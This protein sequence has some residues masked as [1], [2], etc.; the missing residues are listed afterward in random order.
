MKLAI[1]PI[2]FLF[3]IS[4][5]SIKINN[6][7]LDQS[8]S[9]KKLH[10]DI[11]YTEKKLLKLHPNLDWYISKDSLQ[12]EFNQIKKGINT[13]LKPNELFT[14]LAPTIANIRQGHLTLYPLYKKYTKKDV[15]TFGKQKG[16]FSRF[17]YWV[18][19][20]N[21]LYIKE[22]KDRFLNIE[23]GTEILE[24]NGEKIADL[25]NL[26]SAYVT[27]DG[28]NTTHKKYALA[29][30]WT[31][32]YYPEKGI[33][34]SIKFK[35]KYKDEIKEFWAHR[36]SIDQKKQKEETK[37]IHDSVN[38]KDNKNLH[39]NERLGEYNRELK[40]LDSDST[41]AYMKIRSF[42]GVH[43]SAF[44]KKSFNTI[45]QKKV[46]TLIIDVRDNLGGSLS[47][48]NNLYS[49]LTINKKNFTKKIKITN[50]SSIHKTNYF[51]RNT[52]FGKIMDVVLF[53]FAYLNNTLSVKKDN[54]GEYYFHYKFLNEIKE[55]KKD[56]Y[57]GD[58]Y[59]LI[60]GNSF[61]A[62]SIITAKL[63]DDG[64][65]ILVGEETGG[66]HNGTV[67]GRYSTQKLPHSKL[68][69]PIGIMLIQPDVKFDEN[70]KGVQPDV[71]I[72]PSKEDIFSK[73][74]IVLQYV[75][76]RVKIE[77]LLK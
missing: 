19:D 17:S 41:I 5:N 59:F 20:D 74:D 36:E 44:Y 28:Y 70:N 4:C 48:I 45:Q 49:Y 33:F 58:L 6:Q 37:K 26:Y 51:E 11:H 46:K 65:A 21:R 23:P 38:K 75:V 31:A 29:R 10:K 25:M 40:F 2:L 14:R 73:N 77:N 9:I 27:G 35:T 57:Q 76:E 30:R 56:A 66:A 60:N 16:I 42:S 3:L 32:L 12:N 7:N 18:D 43:S 34:D 50:P 53:P 69:I 71:E 13:P 55:I 63:K 72:I 15:K 22:N 67:A 39:Y 24:I 1:I 68:V 61:S 47:E 52:I 54:N 8:L 62:S 64:R